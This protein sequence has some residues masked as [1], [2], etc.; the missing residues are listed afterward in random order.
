MKEIKK[1]TTVTEQVDRLIARGLIIEDRE[2]AESF[3]KCVSYYNFSGYLFEFKNNDDSFDNIRFDDVYNIY[4]CDKRLKSI[5]L[6]AIEIVEHN[7]KTK[8]AYTIAHRLGALGY[9]DKSN[10]S[11]PE[12]HDKMMELFDR[13][14]D[15]NADLAFV[16]HHK[17][18]YS[19][20][21]IWVAIEL[22]TLGNV[23]ACY[24]NIN[25]SIKK[26][27]ASEFS[28]SFLCLENWIDCVVY[29]RNMSAHYMRLYNLNIP[30]TPR[31][32]K[33]HF[34]K[35]SPSNKIF[36]ILY[37]LKLLMPNKEE[38]NNYIL[39]TISDIFEQYSSSIDMM[40]YGFDKNW[41]TLLKI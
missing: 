22:F 35:F 39:P 37:V 5:I 16:K 18:Y 1:P 12:Q 14:I 3:F 41:E 13:S 6:Y 26:E 40:K 9:K 17:K 33:K 19:D 15:K 36:D 38:W 29:L 25:K 24:K 7:I 32:D 27:I 2:F 10:F 20:F 23:S 34:S 30:K 21:P 4:L 8:I 31:T 11:N 28:T